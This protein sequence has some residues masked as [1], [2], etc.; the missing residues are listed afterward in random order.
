MIVEVERSIYRDAVLCSHSDV[1]IAHLH[2][3]PDIRARFSL[4]VIIEFSFNVLG[5]ERWL[6]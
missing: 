3:R 4:H 2:H 5:I 6:T 1:S